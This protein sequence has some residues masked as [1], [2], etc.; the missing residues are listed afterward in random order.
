MTTGD[1]AD[2]WMWFADT[3]C[4]EYSPLYDRIARVVAGSEPVLEMVDA[5]QPNG[6]VPNVLLAAAHFL[7][8]SGADT[9]LADRIRRPLECRPRDAVR[10]LHPTHRDAIAAMLDTRHTNTNEVGRSA[11]VGPALTEVATRLGQPIGLVD[12]GCSAGLNL[13]CDQYRLDYGE[14][15]GTGPT[16]APIQ[17]ACEVR[18]ATPPIVAELPPI[19]ARVGLDRDP[20]DLGDRDSFLWQLACVWPDTGRLDRTRA[21]LEHARDAGLRIV[22]GDAVDDVAAVVRS[23]PDACVPVVVTTWALAYLSVSR[24]AAF[25]ETLTA[26][27]ARPTAG[28]DQR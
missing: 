17:L 3:Q 13:L 23:L 25:A 24:R 6:H 27:G 8:L 28:M 18:G 7:V 4:R 2:L 21:A 5:S 11:V 9:P 26:L 20:V 10:R 19:A 12:V 15:G 14:F 16:D 22:K 1:L